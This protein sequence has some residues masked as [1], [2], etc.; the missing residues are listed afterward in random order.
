M[1]E[2]LNLLEWKMTLIF[3]WMEDNLNFI[4]MEDHLKNNAT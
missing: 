1:E 3:L 2:D 4:Q